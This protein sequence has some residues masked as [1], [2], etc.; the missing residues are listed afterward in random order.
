MMPETPT[1]TT[2]RAEDPWRRIASSPLEGRY[3]H[4]SAWTGDQLV[5]WGGIYRSGDTLVDLTDGAAYNPASD[6]WRSLS[7]APSDLAGPADAVWTGQEMIVRTDRVPDGPAVMAAYQ[8]AA[9]TWRVIEGGPGAVR[10]G[11]TLL[12]TGTDLI[13]WGGNSGDMLAGPTLGAAYDPTTDRWRAIRESPIAPRTGHQTV[14]TGEEM[15]IWGGRGS[16]AGKDSTCVEDLTD[17]AAYNPA[18]DTWRTLPTSGDLQ[19]SAVAVWDG[20]QILFWSQ[21]EC[22]RRCLVGEAYD[23]QTDF[24]LQLPDPPAPATSDLYRALWIGD[25]ALLWNQ[26]GTALTYQPNT[27]TWQTLPPYPSADRR[28]FLTLGWTGQAVIVWGGWNGHAFTP[29]SNDGAAL[30]PTP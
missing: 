20:D 30:D 2:T 11:Y 18:T 26:D 12:W 29:P 25:R 4:G 1:T 7:P 9:D 19:S 23:P 28:F 15:I 6:T 17:G 24:W 14:W 10:E 3:A 5:I 13:I 21:D 8:P 16:C 27:A 22:T